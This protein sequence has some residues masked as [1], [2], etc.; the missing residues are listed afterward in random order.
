MQ[1]WTMLLLALMMSVF[2]VAGCE[3]TPMP[4]MGDSVRMAVEMQKLDPT[5]AGTE[6]VEGLNGEKALNVQNIYRN[7]NSV[8][9]SEKDSSGN[10]FM[11]TMQKE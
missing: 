6:P 1:K 11:G 5:P 4:P 10:K 2:F 9:L 7:K 3:T 8:G